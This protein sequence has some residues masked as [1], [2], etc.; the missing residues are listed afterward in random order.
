MKKGTSP[1]NLFA[2]ARSFAMAARL[3][4]PQ[5]SQAA[6]IPFYFLNGF[7]IEMAL[8]AVILRANRDQGQLK[9]IGHDLLGG[10]RAA[11]DCGLSLAEPE[12]FNMIKR[13]SVVHGDHTF[14]C[15]PDIEEVEVIGPG[16]LETL[17][18]RLLTRIEAEFDVWEDQDPGTA[19]RL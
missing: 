3:L 15:I 6:A 17:L 14:R 13:M 12:T 4:Q 19:K 11:E 16:L 1:P 5:A 7:A 8:K 2:A 18:G 9:R 10:L